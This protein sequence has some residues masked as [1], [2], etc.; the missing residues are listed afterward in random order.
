MVG[1]RIE[2]DCVLWDGCC[3]DLNVSMQCE[4]WYPCY[5]RVEVR[6][7]EFRMWV[8]AAADVERAPKYRLFGGAERLVTW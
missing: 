4:Q 6:I 2:L 7:C 8:V 3:G 5:L 1:D